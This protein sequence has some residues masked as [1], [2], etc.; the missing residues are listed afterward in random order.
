[1]VKYKLKKNPIPSFSFNYLEE[2][3]ISLGITNPSSFIDKPRLED[4]EHYSKLD[5]I[6]IATEWLYEGFKNHK[7]F[8]LQVDSDA[9]GITSSTIFYSF[10]KKL[11]PEANIEWRLHDGKEHG[12]IMDTIP[13]D[14]DYVI[15]PDAGSMQFDEQELLHN[16]GYKLIILDHH[17]VK[18]PPVLENVVIVN[19]QL[20]PNFMN[21]NLSGAGVVYKTIQAFNYIYQDEF[22]LIYENYADLAAL[23]LVADMMDTRN[24]DN[25]YIIWKG[26]NNIKN[27]MLQAL[28]NR[29]NRGFG[30]VSSSTNPNKIDIA[31]YVAPLIN[32]VI[33]FGSPE[34]KEMLFKGFIN[35][36]GDEMM[37]E[38]V[39]RG[40]TRKEA[41]FEYIARI[42]DNIKAR[43]N[44]QKLKCMNFLSNR[45]EENNLNDHQLLIVKISKDDDVTV[46]QTI[47]GLVAMELLKKY[48]KPTLVLRPRKM[49]DGRIQYSGSGRGKQNG[50]FDSLFGMLR[51]SGFCEYVEGHDMAFG[52]AVYEENLPKLIDYANERLKEIEFDVDEAEVDFIFDNNNLNRDMLLEFGRPIHIYGNGIPQ[53]KF[54]FQLKVASSNIFFLGEKGETLKFSLGGIE[55]IKFKCKEL[56]DEIKAANSYMFTIKLVGRVQINSFGGRETPQIRIDDIDME[57]TQLE[58][59]F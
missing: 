8:F 30:G 18:N 9:D 20:S 56:I 57:G 6:Y 54:A 22:P 53:P 49:S 24:L 2:Y 34:E 45:V 32:G 42:S 38:T 39:Y 50:D 19:N 1:M 33:R 26:L 10:F 25:N 17:N 37:V 31:F 46:P 40:I 44:V 4:Q 13:I 43:Q 28:L 47:T 23:G 3:L 41:I 48:K 52:T 12:I 21:K 15:I 55:F 35:E 51:D 7:K 5:N 29:Q 58:S 14:A 36:H 11:F 59:L 27:P 16:R